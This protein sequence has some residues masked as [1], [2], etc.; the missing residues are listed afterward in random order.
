[1]SDVG[2]APRIKRELGRLSMVEID[3]ERVIRFG[4]RR[5]K[6]GGG[7]TAIGIDVGVIILVLPHAAAVHGLPV[8]IEP[9]PYAPKLGS[10]V[11]AS[12]AAHR[13]AQ[14]CAS[15]ALWPAAG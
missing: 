9:R 13:Q 7:P 2:K 8:L 11:T 6:Q 3:R 1:M 14:K 10:F 5:S 4:R 12:G 15:S